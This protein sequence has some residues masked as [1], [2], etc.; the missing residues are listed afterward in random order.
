[1]ELV[2][3]GL[4]GAVGQHELQL[5]HWERAEEHEDEVGAFHAC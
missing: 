1:M 2:P 5:E 3:V 4:P